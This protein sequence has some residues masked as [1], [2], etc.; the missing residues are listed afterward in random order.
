MDWKVRYSKT[1]LR[2]LSRVPEK[3]RASVES[4]A[5]GEAIQKNPFETGKVEK[6]KGHEGYYKARFGVYRVGLR[7]SQVEKTVEFRR[8]LHRREIYRKFP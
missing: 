6:L 8:I 4:F 5:F 1:F 2:E 3:L 7:I